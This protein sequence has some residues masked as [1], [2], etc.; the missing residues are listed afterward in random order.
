MLYFLFHRKRW[1]TSAP[2]DGHCSS[3]QGSPVAG[4]PSAKRTKHS[5]QGFESQDSPRY[6]GR[7]RKRAS[8]APSYSLSP[9]SKKSRT[10][11][12]DGEH[13]VP[14]TLSKVSIPEIECDRGS[15]VSE[16]S[17]AERESGT[18]SKSSS[19]APSVGSIDSDELQRQSLT[20]PI[21]FDEAEM[22]RKVR[23]CVLFFRVQYV[24][25]YEKTHQMGF[26]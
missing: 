1:A 14:P 18:S 15:E 26:L 9:D 3:T 23:N 22:H 19:R 16:L 12:G 2:D 11:A 10:G 25:G 17:E 24:T 21:Q 4:A 8:T 7:D 6:F 20:P 5:S 13:A